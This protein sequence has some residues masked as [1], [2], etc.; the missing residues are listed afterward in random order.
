M[1][2]GTLQQLTVKGV[3]RELQERIDA[4][5]EFWRPHV[6]EMDSTT[7]VE[8]FAWAGAVPQPREMLGERRIKELRTFS[9]N[10]TNKEYE[11]TVLF[12]R[13]WFEDDQTGAIRMRIAEMAEA[14]QKR[15]SEAQRLLAQRSGQLAKPGAIDFALSTPES[16]AERAAGEQLGNELLR[17][18]K[19]AGEHL[20]RGAKA[21]A[22]VEERAARK[23][24]TI[25]ANT[26]VVGIS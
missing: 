20:E 22:D 10:L 4:I 7:E 2:V 5:P 12:P 13:K 18:L 9:H 6:T 25:G 24:P 17:A 19:L 26:L 23:V 8:P 1:A 15:I 3:R 14:A 11:L 16:N 21:S